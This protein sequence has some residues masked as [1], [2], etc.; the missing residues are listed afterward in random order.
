M[1]TIGMD[2]RSGNGQE[3]GNLGHETA[4]RSTL[5]A[6]LVY[7]RIVKNRK[8]DIVALQEVGW[9]GSTVR[10]FCGN[11]TI[12][13]GCGDT[14]ELGTAFMVV[15]EMPVAGQRQNVQ[16]ENQGPVLQ[17]KHN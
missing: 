5:S 14:H 6:A 15:G 2:V 17:C 13:H 4:S 16:V 7:S 9:K 1:D 10:A 8:F 11:H 3:T 12:Y